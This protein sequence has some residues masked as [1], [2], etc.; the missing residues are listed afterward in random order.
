MSARLSRRDL[1]SRLLRPLQK[2]PTG[3]RH[4]IRS[5]RDGAAP[6]RVAVI[7]GRFCIAL[8]SFCS[9][10]VERCPVSGAMK[11]EHGMPV[12]VS[13]VCT[14][15]GVCH[16]VCPAPRNAVLVIPKRPGAGFNS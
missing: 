11:K 7:Q 10:C 16:D 12:V 1:L 3:E 2:G 13:D 5:V 15:C 14:G 9:T 6:D 8:T 4:E